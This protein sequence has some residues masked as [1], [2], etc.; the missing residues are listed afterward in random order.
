MNVYALSKEATEIF[1]RI[2]VLYDKAIEDA[3]DI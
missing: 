2:K 3:R 1:D